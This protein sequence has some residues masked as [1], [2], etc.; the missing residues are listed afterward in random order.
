M[1]TARLSPA[2]VAV[3]GAVFCFLAVGLIVWF[4]I[5]PTLEAL[6]V[7]QARY[8]QNKGDATPQ[9]QAL[10]LNSVKLAQV[11]VAQIKTQWAVDQSRFMPPYDVSNRPKAVAQLNNELGGFLGPDLE[12]QFKSGGVTTTTAVTLPPPPVSPND[13]TAAPLVI[14]LGT[15]TVG[16]DFRRILTNFYNWQYFNRLVLVDNLN[17]S[18]NSPYMTATYTA[19]VYVFPQNDGSLPP[20]IA[21]AGG[22]AAAGTTP[23]G[24]GAF[25]G[26]PRR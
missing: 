20:P 18:G 7:Q 8:D 21:K 6:A 24:P 5:K 9:A 26:G 11:K 1:K 23:G 16:G 3:I 17:M 19:T 10:A 15:V 4:L 13:I 2:I 14:P 12:R 22:G 25:P